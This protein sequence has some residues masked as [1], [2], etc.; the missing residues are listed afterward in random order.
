MAESEVGK[1][2]HYYDKIGVAIL[3]LTDELSVGD[4][5]KFVRGGE[6]LL[7]QQV[8]SIQMEHEQV[9]SAAKGQSVGIKTAEKIHEGAH[10]YKVT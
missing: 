2:V 8:E 4:T 7:E 9:E 5:L 1:V 6:E 3:E 10:A